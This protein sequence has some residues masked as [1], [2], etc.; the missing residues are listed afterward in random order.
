VFW[1][2]FLGKFNHFDAL[3]EG[4]SAASFCHQVA[5]WFPDVLQFLFSETSQN[6]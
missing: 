6:T 3:D 1:Q 5:A 4:E 2:V